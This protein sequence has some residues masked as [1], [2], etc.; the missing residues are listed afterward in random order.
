[1]K[2]LSPL[3]SS[4]QICMAKERG[5]LGKQNRRAG[6]YTR[7]GT[8][9]EVWTAHIDVPS[10]F[11]SDMVDEKCWAGVVI[12]PQVYIRIEEFAAQDVFLCRL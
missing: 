5:P 9:L 7:R 12:S 8:I 1:M 10:H 6:A 3:Y 11:I 4:P 2:L